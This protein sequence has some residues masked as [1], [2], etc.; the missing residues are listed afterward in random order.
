MSSGGAGSSRRFPT[1]AEFAEAFKNQPQYRRGATRFILCRF[2][3]SFAHKE[4]VNLS[5]A[6]I[7]HVLPQVMTPVWKAELGDG[8]EKIHARFIDTFGNLT[9]TGYNSELGNLSFAEKIEK[10]KGTHIELNRRILEQANW[11]EQ[12]I[13][14]RAE[15]LLIK[16]TGLWPGPSF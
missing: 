13:T 9:L 2:E 15:A 5:V 10:L 6:T 12:E 1:D 3:K 8:A 14:D 4:T 16:A 7:E 11:R